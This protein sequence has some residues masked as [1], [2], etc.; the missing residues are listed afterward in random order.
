MTLIES[1]FFDFVLDEEEFSPYISEYHKTIPLL[2]STIDQMIIFFKR[3]DEYQNQYCDLIKL[4]INVGLTSYSELF[5]AIIKYGE[6]V[7]MD[8]ECLCVYDATNMRKV[9]RISNYKINLMNV[10]FKVENGEKTTKW[11]LFS[12]FLSDELLQ[13]D[14]FELSNRFSRYL[15]EAKNFQ[16]IIKEIDF[17]FNFIKTI[18]KPEMIE[19]FAESAL[20]H[21]I[22]YNNI[23]MIAFEY[24]ASLGNID[25]YEHLA[26][27]YIKN[28]NFEKGKE[29]A[30]I[31]IKNKK[32]GCT[33]L[34]ANVYDT[35]GNYSKAFEYYKIS[36]KMGNTESM[37]KVGLYDL[38]G[39]HGVKDDNRGSKYIIKSAQEGNSTAQYYLAVMY[40]RG[41]ILKIN[42]VNAFKYNELSI[43]Q[44]NQTG[45]F[46]RGLFYFY[47]LFVN[48]NVTRAAEIFEQIKEQPRAALYLAT[49]HLFGLCG[50][51][52]IE[53]ANE[54][55][56]LTIGG[57]ST[58]DTRF[59]CVVEYDPSQKKYHVVNE[60]IDNYFG[61][62]D[63]LNA[64]I[65]Q[66]K[67]QDL[68]QITWH[69]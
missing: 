52:D 61:W 54:Y 66:L 56:K 60:Q 42:Y 8:V 5:N 37:Y 55:Y 31:A 69:R 30:E 12:R 3:Y 32:Y 36:A 9:S 22:S 62:N 23:V 35:E 53:K 45:M 64:Q 39:K 29:Y 40:F 65:L 16:C 43:E 57:N 6:A 44:G 26:I 33:E 51:V 7:A 63:L 46:M 13:M 50:T 19:I 28:K 21:Y 25:A 59:L 10:I 41:I 58:D 34:L 1:G 68:S 11:L 4:A 20:K 67:Q 47:G 48:Q 17:F 38:E 14:E 2:E 27:G 49:I 18:N 15:S 24:L